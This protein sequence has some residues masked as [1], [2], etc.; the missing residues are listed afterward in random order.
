MGELDQDIIQEHVSYYKT[1]NVCVFVCPLS[2]LVFTDRST[3]NLAGRSG[4][5]TENTSRDLFPWKPSCCHGNQKNNVFMAR[6]WLWL[7]IRLPVMSQSM[8]SHRQWRHI[9]H[10]L[11]SDVMETIYSGN[12]KMPSLENAT[13]LS[14]CA[15]ESQLG[16]PLAVR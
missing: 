9:W 12:L 5:V 16:T 4:T 10:H 7:D 6:S 1:R 11:G 3:P 2:P 13:F 15:V 8:T 14:V